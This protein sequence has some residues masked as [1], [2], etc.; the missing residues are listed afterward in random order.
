MKLKIKKQ[1]KNEQGSAMVIIMMLIGS[2][3]TVGTVSLY[4]AVDMR[5]SVTV[6][7]FDRVALNLADAA[8]MHAAMDMKTIEN[9]NNDFDP[10][11]D[12]VAT[13]EIITVEG[14]NYDIGNWVAAQTVEPRHKY[15]AW[16]TDNSDVGYVN[17][18]SNDTITNFFLLATDDVDG[19]VVFIAKGW[20]EDGSGG[21]IAT[22]YLKGLYKMV[23]Y[24]PKFAILAGGDMDLKGS[25]TIQGSKPSL[26]TNGDF[27][28]TG[29]GDF[30]EGAV[31]SS[32]ATSGSVTL[33]DGGSTGTGGQP[34]VE[35]P[36]FSAAMFKGLAAALTYDA[37][38][39]PIVPGNSI[40]VSLTANT[41]V[42]ISFNAPGTTYTIDPPKA[43]DALCNSATDTIE[44]GV[45]YF[46]ADVVDDTGGQTFPAVIIATGDV[47]LNTNA[48]LQGSTD[49]PG[50]GVVS[51]G[52]VAFS[53]TVTVGASPGNQLACYAQ[54][55]FDFQG[56]GAKVINGP[57][58]AGS[59]PS[60]VVSLAGNITINY[61]NESYV[62]I[63]PPVG[64]LISWTKI[65]E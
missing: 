6:T 7:K 45:F 8:L 41:C 59:A 54:A 50:V 55:G 48:D 11:L 63:G 53:G 35:I 14:A 61:D 46:D 32:G 9:I 25:V 40:R 15:Q 29:N 34:P 22:A 39:T 23:Q 44:G 4:T 30:A 26:H 19:A 16:V 21:E 43:G 65:D 13:K 49:L 57:L 28:S 64:K 27:S 2:M 60:T 12:T 3:L 36:D 51:D 18:P 17:G 56:G 38:A 58:I 20:V 10:E 37:T 42:K 31:T 5:R 24:D 47:K 1:V 33:L 52:Q 62:G